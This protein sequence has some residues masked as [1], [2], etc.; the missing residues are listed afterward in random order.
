MTFLKSNIPV[1]KKMA[2]AGVS[3]GVSIYVWLMREQ[4]EKR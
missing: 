3:I 1:L 4:E 2:R